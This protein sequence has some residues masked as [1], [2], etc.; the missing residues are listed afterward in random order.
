M[1]PR[2]LPAFTIHTAVRQAKK[3]FA[4][5]KNPRMKTWGPTAT[6][7]AIVPILPFLFDR[8]VEHATEY[9]FEWIERKLS[10]E[11]PTSEPLPADSKKDV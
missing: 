9:A 10:S 4:G 1:S 2:A 3:A 6:G 11:P 5:S 7:L 8:P